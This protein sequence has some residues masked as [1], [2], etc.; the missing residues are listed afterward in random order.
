[1]PEARV[2]FATVLLLHMEWEKSRF[3]A[4]FG[5]ISV[6]KK[7]GTGKLKLDVERISCGFLVLKKEM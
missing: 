4:N 5:G 7:L 3:R 1:M 2:C 6:V